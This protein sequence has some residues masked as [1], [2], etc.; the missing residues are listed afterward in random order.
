VGLTLEIL[1]ALVVRKR[2][3]EGHAEFSLY[4]YG[5]WKWW[6]ET[7]MFFLLKGRE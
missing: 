6:W 2:L 3:P 1:G 4:A 5:A 7:K